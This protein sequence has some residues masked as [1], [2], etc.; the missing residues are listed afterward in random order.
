M[1]RFVGI[2]LVTLSQAPGATERPAPVADK[3]TAPALWDVTGKETGRV[4]L[5][6]G[7]SN[8]SS[9]PAFEFSLIGNSHLAA[10]YAFEDGS[11]LEI[12]PSGSLLSGRVPL[13][14]TDYYRVWAVL[15]LAEAGLSIECYVG[16]AFSAECFVG[17][18]RRRP[19]AAVKWFPIKGLSI[20]ASINNCMPSIDISI[21]L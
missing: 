2:V 5:P 1:I 13:Y 20:S 12:R 7:P 6:L 21:D 10:I 16:S 18:G 14:E 8:E 15:G 4:P 3:P 19:Y 17:A 11:Q 9:G